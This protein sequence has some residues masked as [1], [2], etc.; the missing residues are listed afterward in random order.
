MVSLYVIDASELLRR[1]LR[2]ALSETPDLT[3]AGESAR[4][5]DALPDIR[6]LTP[7]VVLVDLDHDTTEKLRFCEVVTT[8]P[9]P[10]PV[11]VSLRSPDRKQVGAAMLAGAAGHLVITDPVDEILDRIRAAHAAPPMLG[12]ELVGDLFARVRRG[13][14]SHH[15]P[16]A[17]LTA[18][19]RQIMALLADGLDNRRIGQALHL[20]PKTVKNYVSAILHKLGMASRTE[21]AVLA[22]REATRIDTDA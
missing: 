12:P 17:D 5:A 9:H 4:T 22:A 1:G 20:S 19:E 11:L 6:R 10:T 2:A 3:V 8:E 13:R 21:A 7:D 16:L 15:D 14:P 18:R